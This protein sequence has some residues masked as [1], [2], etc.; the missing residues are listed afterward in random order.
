MTKRFTEVAELLR[1]G[2]MSAK[3]AA[4]IVGVHY[5][6][7]YL[8]ARGVHPPPRSAILCLESV[9]SGEPVGSD[10]QVFKGKL[11]WA[12]K[13]LTV[14][15]QIDPSYASSWHLKIAN[16]VVASGVDPLQANE[17][18]ARFM[19]AAFQVDTITGSKYELDNPKGG[20]K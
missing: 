17:A 9:I 15:V 2:N 13:T 11:M 18:A 12:L 7:V 5:D 19:Y 3:T 1:R 16:A 10:A 8:W 14:A 4:K 6:T 20:D